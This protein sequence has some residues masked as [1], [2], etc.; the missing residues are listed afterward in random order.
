MILVRQLIIMAQLPTKV[1]D[2]W[3]FEDRNRYNGNLWWNGISYERHGLNTQVDTDAFIAKNWKDAVDNYIQNPSVDLFSEPHLLNE[4]AHSVEGKVALLVLFDQFPRNIYR[5][6]K[7]AFA[8]D[9]YALQV[10]NNLLETDNVNSLPSMYLLC[11]Y[12]ALMHSEQLQHISTAHLGILKLA[13][14]H[15]N[16]LEKPQKTYLSL[17]KMSKTCEKHYKVIQKFGRYP[18]RNKVIGRLSTP[19]ELQYLESADLPKWAKTTPSTGQGTVELGK[20][21]LKLL[22]LHSNRQTAARFENKTKNYV[23]R[24][25]KDTCDLIYVDAPQLYKPSGE[26]LEQNEDKS[27]PNVGF[28]KSWWNATDDPKTMTYRG[29]EDSLKY[30]DELFKIHEFDGIFGFSQGGTLTGIVAN[31]VQNMNDGKYSPVNLSNVC[32]SLRF[33]IIISGFYCRDIRKGFNSILSQLPDSHTEMNVNVRK[34]FIKL[35]SYHCWGKRDE[36]VLPWRSQKLSEAFADKRVFVHESS[37]FSQAIKKWPIGDIVQWL[38]QFLPVSEDIVGIC[39]SIIDKVSGVISEKELSVYLESSGVEDASLRLLHHAISSKEYSAKIISDLCTLMFPDFDQQVGNLLQ[40]A[41]S[42]DMIWKHLLDIDTK[43]QQGCSSPLRQLIV[44]MISS[45]LAR[46]YNDEVKVSKLAIHAPRRNVVYKETGLF[47]DVVKAVANKINI[48]RHECE[49]VKQSLEREDF[50]SEDAYYT[51]IKIQYRRMVSELNKKLALPNLG[52]NQKIIRAKTSFKTIEEG[53]ASP[54]SDFIKNPRAEPMDLAPKEQ[55]KELHEYLQNKAHDFSDSVS[56]DKVFKHGILFNDPPRL[57]LC[58]QMIGPAG[59]DNLLKSLETDSMRNDPFVKHLLL[60]NNVCGNRLGERVGRFIKS[61]KSKLTTWYIAGNDLDEN[62]IKPVCDALSED[63]LVKQLWLKRN[64]LRLNGA[65][66][67]GNML[68]HNTTL[69]VLDLANTAMFDDGARVILENVGETLKC[70]YLSANGL[71][72]KTCKVFAAVSKNPNFNLDTICFGCNRIGDEGAKYVAEALAMCNSPLRSV[73]LSSCAIGPNGAKHLAEAVKDNN[74]LVLLKLGLMKATK[75][76][77][78]IPNKIKTEGG[79]YFA[80]A[81]STNGSL[82]GLDLTYN[83][84]NQKAIEKLA[85]VLLNL[86][87][88]LVYFNIE[89]FGNPHNELSREIIRS[90]V[91]RNFL[92]LTDVELENFNYYMRPPHIEE[93]ISVTRIE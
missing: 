28:T 4:W 2:F 9:H 22:V 54:L 52:D 87:D 21:K 68:C 63:T 37:H 46:E 6:S 50:E 34:N 79:L 39:N 19:E 92:S 48:Y 88:S 38:Q 81:L 42:D 29:L 67:L 89:Q 31:L 75:D 78:E 10:A 3:F 24:I 51:S 66:H 25:L 23:E 26:I 73:S 16:D 70:L 56:E 84:I 74:S 69:T 11:I 8:L 40:V 59:I 33:V 12:V 71:T 85:F 80:D 47:Y 72:E 86:N 57:D 15:E 44:E 93:I 20:K 30:V 1:L 35:P 17:V 49:D 32:D 27:I 61:K 58:K 36:L 65:I 13:R 82:R 62:G 18:H 60:G 91:R 55:L 83:N 45:E 64:P 7:K 53:L 14:R 76:L 5:N 41:N 90:S 77:E 43:H